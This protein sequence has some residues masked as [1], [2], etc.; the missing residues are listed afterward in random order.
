MLSPGSNLCPPHPTSQSAGSRSGA[1]PMAV[2]CKPLVPTNVTHRVVG[3]SAALGK[4]LAK[5]ILGWALVSHT[6]KGE[7]K[8]R[9]GPWPQI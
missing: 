3:C 4:L 8:K 2:A 9:L 5:A 1:A 6:T 7:E